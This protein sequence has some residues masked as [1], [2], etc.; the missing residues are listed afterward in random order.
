MLP[1]APSD[2]SGGARL[3][4]GSP[5]K[6]LSDFADLAEIAQLFSGT[7]D[8]NNVGGRS[9]WV[10]DSKINKLTVP[11]TV[12]CMAWLAPRGANGNSCREIALPATQQYTGLR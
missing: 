7:A 10:S 5:T 3:E 6:V 12:Q 11:S 1:V 4:H 8:N 2:D 9:V